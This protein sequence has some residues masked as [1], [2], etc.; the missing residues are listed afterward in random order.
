MMTIDGLPVSIL[1][2][3]R[4]NMAKR[5]FTTRR[6]PVDDMRTLI[7]GSVRPMPGDL[8][9]ASVDEIGKQTRLE[10]TNGRRA[11]MFLGDEIVVCFGNRYAPDQFE[12]IVGPDLSGCDLV[13]GG[14]LAARELSRHERMIQPTR[15]SP[16][17][18]IGDA[19]A[20]RLN[21][22][23]YAIARENDGGP[24][25]TV[26]VAGT[27]M[28]SGK[29]LTSAS[30]VRGLKARGHRVAAIKATGT[31]AGGDLWIM[32]DVGADVVVDFT[33]AGFAS[34]YKAPIEEIEQA[35]LALIRHAAQAGCTYAV[36]EIADG[37][38]QPETA[39]LLR[40]KALRLRSMGVLFAAYDAMGAK[41]GTDALRQIGHRVL[42]VSGKLTRSSLA[43]REAEQATGCQAFTPAQLQEG[44][45]V[46]ALIERTG[47]S[48]GLP[49]DIT[50]KS[51]RAM[52]ANGKVHLKQS[53]HIEQS[54]DIAVNDIKREILGFVASE[55][56]E[57]QT[58]GLCG[59]ARGKRSPNRKN[60]RNGYRHRSWQ[61]GDCIVGL[62]IPR[63]RKDTYFPAFLQPR[64]A[65][66]QAL[67]AV[68][69]EAQTGSLTIRSVE[70]LVKA[71]GMDHVKRNEVSQL[72]REILEK[73]RA[74]LARSNE[75][76]VKPCRSHD[77]GSCN[78]NGNGEF[79]HN[80]FGNHDFDDA[81]ENEANGFGHAAV[82]RANAIYVGGPLADEGAAAAKSG[83]V[84]AGVG[85]AP[86]TVD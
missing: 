11:R 43:I 81:V 70:E 27:S 63:L 28:N 41:A 1:E 24:I 4:A 65:A 2:P 47:T 60:R 37:L 42:A 72:H 59:A 82:N 40:S 25:T 53:A 36:I 8:V 55:L 16:I 15:I 44:V 46:G 18:L 76:V 19:N 80:G 10:L 66:E 61:A 45:I 86:L 58:D 32:W 6:V 68:V 79:G 56:M 29:T 84:A 57:I 85:D 38:Q 49:R 7:G 73:A 71:M 22:R 39:A 51:G 21:V 75:G 23:D 64:T 67:Y 52:A 31:G 50:Q 5:A 30:I 83:D 14:G 48:D 74:L 77:A 69:G 3:G 62:R 34:T 20:T 13:A 35:T 78:G 17:G 54:G 9:L 33:D 26:L 12:A